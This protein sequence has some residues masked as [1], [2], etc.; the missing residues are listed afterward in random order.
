MSIKRLLNSELP[1]LGRPV[2]LE[3]DETQH[4]SQVLRLRE[5]DCVQ[6]L[7]GNGHAVLATLKFQS[8]NI[9]LEYKAPL[10]LHPGRLPIFLEMAILKG[11]A[12]EWVIEK[13][14]EL[15]VQTLTPLFT[16][17]TVIQTGK[18][19]PQ[20]FQTRWKK[21]A[22]QALK[23]CGRTLRMDIQEPIKIE[24]LLQNTPATS[25]SPRL[26]FD[27]TTTQNPE[28]KSELGHWIQNNQAHFPSSIHL[29]IGPEGGWDPSEREAL[30]RLSIETTARLSLGPL[31]LRAE[32]AVLSSI[33]LV[34][35]AFRMHG[36]LDTNH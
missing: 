31:V 4:A 3:K 8:K 14:V 27:E 30:Q 25:L 18:K 26:W 10:D 35:A 6:V 12:M 22:D 17:N 34:T 11:D 23:Q 20:A 16:K 33:A 5:G 24:S 7:D 21:I 13:A 32:T 2:L 19:D 1:T 36:V 29:L 28:P 9:Q 15:G